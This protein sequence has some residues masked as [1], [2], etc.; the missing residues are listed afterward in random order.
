M[1]AQRQRGKAGEWTPVLIGPGDLPLSDTAVREAIIGSG[2]ILDPRAQANYRQ[3]ASTDIV[4][5]DDRTGAARSL[6]RS[7]TDSLVVQ[8]N[9]RAAERAATAL[10]LMSIVGSRGGGKQG[11]TDA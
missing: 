4:G 2:L 7:R 8:V 5:G 10:F 11:A 6:D 1:Y 9:P 3:I